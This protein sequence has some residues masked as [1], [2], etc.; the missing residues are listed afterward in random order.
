MNWTVLDI[1]EYL[2]GKRGSLSAADGGEN[3]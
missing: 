2:H 1:A 3:G